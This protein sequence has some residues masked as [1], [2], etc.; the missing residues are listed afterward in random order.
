MLSIEAI[1]APKSVLPPQR[2]AI[3]ERSNE[4][5]SDEAGIKA[6]PKSK[7]P[8][9]LEPVD[10]KLAKKEKKLKEKEEDIE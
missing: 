7:D 3:S 1:D 2:I 10:P 6:N 4:D 8:F 9:S 5:D